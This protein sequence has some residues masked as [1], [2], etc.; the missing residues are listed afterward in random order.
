MTV[1]I[2]E[3]I[4]DDII[5]RHG[6]FL[7]EKSAKKKLKALFNQKKKEKY[8]LCKPKWIDLESFGLYGD[9]SFE[10]GR[11]EINEVYVES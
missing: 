3:E 7:S 10:Y 9:N 8:T 2:V 6:I 5:I 4:Y 11:F 1:Y